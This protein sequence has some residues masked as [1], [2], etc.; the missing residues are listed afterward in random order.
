HIV[1]FEGDCHMDYPYNYYTPSTE[2]QSPTIEITGGPTG[3]IDYND[4]TFTWSGN[5]PD[6]EVQGYYYGL[7]NASPDTWTTETTHTFK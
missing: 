2:N 7:D 3:T 6:G 4:V 5:D 1:T